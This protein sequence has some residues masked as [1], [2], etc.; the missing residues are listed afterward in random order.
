MVARQCLYF[1]CILK[2]AVFFATVSSNGKGYD[3]HINRVNAVFPHF[4]YMLGV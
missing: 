3:N 2:G 1:N 4:I